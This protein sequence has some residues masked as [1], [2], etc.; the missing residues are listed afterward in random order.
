M[1]KKDVRVEDYMNRNV[2]FVNENQTVE[3]VEREMLKQGI[4]GFPVVDDEEH[5]T[6]VINVMDLFFKHPQMEIKKLMTRKVVSVPKDIKI[7]HAARIMFRKGISRVPVIE[8]NKIV[9][10]FT[11]SDV[12][13]AHIERVTPS[14]VEK[15]KESFEKIYGVKI[16]LADQEVDVEKLI[17]SQN[18]IDLDELEGR[19][20][21]LRKGLAEPIVVVRSEG[22]LVIADGH[23]RSLA[24]HKLGIQKINAYILIPGKE[25]KTGL[26][27]EAGRLNLKTVA[28]IRINYDGQ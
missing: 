12:L 22:G 17:P 8:E 5:I 19:K 21:E 9:G 14:K 18:S 15:I 24:A 25:I 28:D 23:H 1:T 6:G 10:I 27:K 16:T 11:H 2:I 26:E 4:D 20:Y 13:R 7:E 3:D